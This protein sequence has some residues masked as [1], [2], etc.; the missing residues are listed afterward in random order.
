MRCL[1]PSQKP[2][3]ECND[4]TQEYA[5]REGEIEGEVLPLD[6]DVSGELAK[7]GDLP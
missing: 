1:P 5:R 4:D 2:E 3:N 6:Y 7:Q